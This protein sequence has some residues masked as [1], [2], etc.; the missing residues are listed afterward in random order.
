MF[1]AAASSVVCSVNPVPSVNDPMRTLYMSLYYFG[2]T[3]LA[4]SAYSQ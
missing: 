1:L 4:L 2:L 3:L